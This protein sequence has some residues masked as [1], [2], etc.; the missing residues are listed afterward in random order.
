MCLAAGWD[1]AVRKPKSLPIYNCTSGQINALNYRE[2]LM[3][4]VPK[5]SAKYPMSEFKNLIFTLFKIF[6]FSRCN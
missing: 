3:E 1:V 6:F 2:F 5:Y 4:L